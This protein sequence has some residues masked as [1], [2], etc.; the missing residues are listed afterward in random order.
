MSEAFLSRWAKRKQ[1][2]QLGT[3]TTEAESEAQPP[4]Q[5][6]EAANPTVDTEE[7]VQ[8]LTDADMPD[9]ETLNSQSDVSMFFAKG[10]SQSLRKQAL[11]KLFHQPEFNYRC[12][13]DEYA[14]DYSQ[15]PTLASEAVEKLRY[16][17]KG[18]VDNW[19]EDLET[20]L[21]ETPEETKDLENSNNLANKKEADD[22]QA[23]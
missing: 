23:T 11:R 18:R 3:A 22:D 16:W 17:A 6:Q 14:E 19:K 8:E 9:L 5:P 4:A 12:P 10:V 2:Q 15:M 1:E 20:E 21:Q 7:R 13:M